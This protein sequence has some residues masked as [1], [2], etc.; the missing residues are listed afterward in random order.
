MSAFNYLVSKTIMHV[1]SPI[2]RFFAKDYVAG[3]TI[4][5]AIRV[6]RQLH[7]KGVMGTL[8]ILGEYITKKE[9]A[10]PFKQ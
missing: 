3:N 9:Q 4:E 1:P 7:A 5:D 2:V 10:I 8:D 6:T